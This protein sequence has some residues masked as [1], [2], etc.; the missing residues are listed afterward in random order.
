[1]EGCHA[2]AGPALN[3]L[4]F[5]CTVYESLIEVGG[6]PVQTDAFSNGVKLH[7]LSWE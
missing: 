7:V 3:L 2:K 6:Q 5:E 1:M 4:T